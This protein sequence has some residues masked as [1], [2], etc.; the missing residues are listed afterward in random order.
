MITFKACMFNETTE[1]W[2]DT[3]RIEY[4]I[5]LY[6]GDQLV[7]GVSDGTI[8]SG[9]P[10]SDFSYNQGNNIGRAFEYAAKRY[11]FENDAW[12]VLSLYRGQDK[13]SRITW[14]HD[15]PNGFVI[16][17][18][19]NNGNGDIYRW[20]HVLQWT[21]NI[22]TIY[23]ESDYVFDP[24]GLDNYMVFASTDDIE[25]LNTSTLVWFGSVQASDSSDK[26]GYIG[27][28][29]FQISINSDILKIVDSAG[30]FLGNV[31][32]RFFYKAYNGP[33]I[34]VYL[35]GS[36]Y[37]GPNLYVPTQ[38]PNT[39]SV[40]APYNGA[41][42]MGASQ[43]APNTGVLGPYH[44]VKWQRNSNWHYPPNASSYETGVLN[45]Y[46]DTTK[47]EVA[48]SQE[49]LEN[50]NIQLTYSK[51]NL[52]IY[53]TDE[54]GNPDPKPTPPPDVDPVNPPDPDVDP[55]PIP[56]DNQDPYY[57][58]TSD[59]KDPTYDPTKDPKDPEYD[60]TEPHT[61]FRPPSTTDGGGPAPIQPV[62]GVVS[63]PE[64]PP[65]F[66][67]NN[68]LF[69]LY[70]PSGGDLNNL[71][72]FL[73]SPTWSIDT[74]KK[75]FV[76]PMDCILGLMVM[77]QLPADVGT[78]QMNFGN[79]PTGISMHY[80][81]KQFCDFDC[82]TFKLEEFYMSYLDYTPYTKVSI[83]LPYIG[84]VELSTDEVMNTTIGVKYR[85]DI[86]CGACVAFVSVDG[87][88]LYSFSGNCAAHIP[89][90]ANDWGSTVT[91]LAAVPL[92]AAKVGAIIGGGPVGA[93]G[94]AA[95]ISVMSM[96]EKVTHSGTLKG[97]AGLMG[98]QTP[99]LIVNRPRQAAPLNQN[100]YTGYPSFITESLGSLHGYTE[101]EQCH[102]DH[103][104]ATHEELAEIERL[105]KEGVML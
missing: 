3:V 72:D 66:V 10:R 82:G 80:F 39:N 9:M 26:D 48:I 46:K 57:D 69:T 41:I 37:Q 25:V 77:P 49:L 93:L 47:G 97:S 21:D 50:A 61:P 98:I 99:Y 24:T 102:L 88:V 54:G 35:V 44:G 95:A 20:E 18:N 51:T 53:L 55:D 12:P 76:N 81:T 68:S 105:L 91:A 16:C 6:T 103:I 64:A 29:I 45:E 63:I 32:E 31:R 4:S 85:F 67:T 65:A 38:G 34:G 94:A 19:S 23:E 100:S 36:D 71:A 87:N 78:K 89:L 56:P 70:N 30:A 43:V 73:W 7:A 75:I 22:P 1:E 74:L 5:G 101:V 60:P 28:S 33:A 2:I 14:S 90:S 92:G 40:L 52:Y 86:S 15:N 83:F 13:N 62:P 84:E 11:F 17:T 42:R 59:P 79:I 104:P 27:Y 96:K 8:V 58:P